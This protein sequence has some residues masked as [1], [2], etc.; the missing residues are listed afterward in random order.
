MTSE[1]ESQHFI[2]VHRTTCGRASFPFPSY[3]DGVNGRRFGVPVHILAVQRL[4]RQGVWAV[5]E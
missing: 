4:P 3:R 5:K 2:M 1:R